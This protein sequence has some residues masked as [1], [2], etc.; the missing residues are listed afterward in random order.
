MLI[1]C[2]LL[3][4][5]LSVAITIFSANSDKI[6]NFKEEKT[7]YENDIKNM[8]DDIRKYMF[9]LSL[10]RFQEQKKLMTERES[11]LIH[12]YEDQIGSINSSKTYLD[13]CTVSYNNFI[14]GFFITGIFTSPISVIVTFSDFYRFFD[15]KQIFYM[16]LVISY[17][18]FIGIP[19]SL[20]FLYLH[21]KY[22]KKFKGIYDSVKAKL[23]YVKLGINR[24]DIDEK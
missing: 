11:T 16:A 12:N 10:S 9:Y 21:I 13:E 23:E 4:A 17:V 6:F 19:I 20:Y 8:M 7:K 18:I 5:I 15:E 22:K 14:R 3:F 24:G 1:L 2:L